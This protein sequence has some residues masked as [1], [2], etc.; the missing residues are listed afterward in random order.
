[1]SMVTRLEWTYRTAGAN[2]SGTSSEV[3]VEVFRD[4]EVLAVASDAPGEADHLDHEA[5]ATRVLTLAHP[6]NGAADV[7]GEEFPEGV[8][9]HLGVRFRVHGYDAWQIDK[10]ESTVVVREA[11]PSPDG[12][13][14]EETREHFEF[15]GVG[16]LR[17]DP[18]EG[19]AIL[20]LSY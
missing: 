8:H 19:T 7:S 4:G 3:R 14:W 10:I 1:M 12:V 9:G 11:R 17:A 20:D 18:C 16:V 2:G 5:L 6:A 15:P 13:R